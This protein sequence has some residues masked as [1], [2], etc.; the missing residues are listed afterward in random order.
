MTDLLPLLG[1]ALVTGFLGSAHCFGMCGGISGLIGIDA[2]SASTHTQLSRT[3][4]YNL[5]R[6]ATYAL[7]GALVALLGQSLVDHAIAVVEH[8]CSD[9]A[10]ICHIDQQGTT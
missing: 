3:L 6:V 2:A 5:G 7:L 8:R 9:L 1:A 4:S 10:T